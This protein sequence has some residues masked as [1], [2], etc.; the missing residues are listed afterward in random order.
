MKF[1]SDLVA[2]PVDH[3]GSDEAIIK[4]MLVS[5]QGELAQQDADPEAMRGRI[6][7]LMANKHGTPFEHG[8][9]T[10]FVK[11]PIFVFREFHR[12]RIGFSYNEESGRYKK[13]MPEFYVP[14]AH[15]PLRQ[16]G[17]PG[18]YEFEPG[19]P[20]QYDELISTMKRRARDAYHDYEF[21]LNLGIAKEVA[22]MDLPLNIYSS[23]YVTC[24]PRSLMSFLALRTNVDYATF[25]SK[26]MWEIE[27]IADDLELMFS[28]WFPVTHWSWDRNGRVAP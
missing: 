21:R 9:M 25:P 12:H 3:M 19:T 18:A 13:L 4:A 17:K 15:R 11:A 28:R 20:E 7:F 26:P 27:Q 24:N 14:P 22:R 23:M 6:N 8:S 1:T 5:T 2:L 10:F 16:V